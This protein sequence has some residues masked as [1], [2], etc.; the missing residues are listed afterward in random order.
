VSNR[1]RENPLRMIEE[2]PRVWFGK[3]SSRQGSHFL[4]VLWL[5]SSPI[6]PVGYKSHDRSF[7]T[8]WAMRWDRLSTVTRPI[9]SS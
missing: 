8:A 5:V 4:Q 6:F 2:T 1:L 7:L 3:D 9:S